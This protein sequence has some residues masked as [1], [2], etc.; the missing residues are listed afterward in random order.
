MN[1]QTVGSSAQTSGFPYDRLMLRANTLAEKGLG[2]TAPNPIVGALI[3]NEFGVEISS[4]F[5]AGGDHAEIVAIN[6]A[7]KNGLIDFSNCTLIVTLEPC[8]HFGKTPPCSQAIIDSGI[9]R[10]VFALSD[11]NEAAAGGAAKLRA[12]NIE[13]ISDVQASF[14]A[15]SNRAWLKKVTKSKPWIVSKIAATIDGKIAASDG[16]SKWITGQSA[17][18]DVARIRFQSDAILTSTGT[19]LADDSHLVPRFANESHAA[20]KSGNPTR[21][22]MG[23]REIPL[24]F[25][26][27]DDAAK[28]IFLKTHDF[29]ELFDLAIEAGWNQVLVEAGSEFN[30][31]LMKADLVDELLIYFAPTTLGLGKSFLAD[32]GISTLTER[33]DFGFGEIARV[34]R[35]LRIQMFSNP[36]SYSEIFEK[37]TNLEEAR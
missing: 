30:T 37:T 15:F 2:L 31:A 20:K 28:T 13:V 14:V 27:H 5:H 21:V 36:S 8:N 22:V 1:N 33:K 12:A 23:R 24:S 11:P 32:L 29:V 34:G 16:S 26:V 7:R 35:D 18:S 4:G 17:R 9:R 3:V 25:K 10:V 19:V 6:E